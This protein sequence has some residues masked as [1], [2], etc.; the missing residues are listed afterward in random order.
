MF[1]IK[2]LSPAFFLLL[3]LNSNNCFVYLMLTIIK[4]IASIM[5]KLLT[6]FISKIVRFS[7]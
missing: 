2:I 6:I 5:S 1:F 3:A 4:F 7:Y